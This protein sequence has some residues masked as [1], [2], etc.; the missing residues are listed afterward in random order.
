MI[1]Y[2]I[3]I[4]S[5]SFFGCSDIKN[6]SA[7][8]L[9]NTE[10]IDTLKYSYSGFNNGLNLNLLSNGNFEYQEF[11]YGCTGGGE[12][13][14][15]TG[16]YKIDSSFLKLIPSKIKL[17]TY[18][19]EFDGETETL[20]T[21]YGIDS[22]KI[23]TEF[24]IVKWGNS[25]YLLSE[26]FDLGWSIEE[27]NDFIRFSENFNSG[28]EP[29]NSGRYLKNQQKDSL[30]K[31]LDLKQIPRK[32]RELF[33]ISPLSVK[34]VKSTKKNRFSEG[35]NQTYWILEIDKGK[36]DKVTKGMTFQTE[37][38]DAFFEIDSVRQNKS[39]SKAYNY[40]YSD[41]K[42]FNIGTVYQTKWK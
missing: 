40:N 7:K 11:V 24:N 15:V 3:F 23:K 20:E 1:K 8:I 13:K 12:N 34:I 33:L 5:I 30:N 41:E 28:Y 27:K 25:S 4:L 42:Y 37:N 35:E 29:S 22:L 2:I 19:M 21:K 31:P 18:P 17:L 9:I 32:W 26:Q 16:K 14:K 10:Q 38:G 36:K 6:D 39:F